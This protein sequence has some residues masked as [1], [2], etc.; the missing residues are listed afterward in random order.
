MLEK[1]PAFQLELDP[2]CSNGNKDLKIT[3]KNTEWN[4]SNV[5]EKSKT[6]KFGVEISSTLNDVGKLFMK[7]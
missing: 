1:S 6:S 2:V 7:D 4:T 5:Q 3:H